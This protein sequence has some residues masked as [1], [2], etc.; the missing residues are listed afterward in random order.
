MGRSSIGRD[1]Q[2]A[3]GGS[4]SRERAACSAVLRGTLATPN[5]A[6]EWMASQRAEQEE[7]VPGSNE[8]SQ[9]LI[10]AQRL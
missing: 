6:I 7:F 5:H 8:Q 1:P 10:V 4:A 2:L 3:L 9:P